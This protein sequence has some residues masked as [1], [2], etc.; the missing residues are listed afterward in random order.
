MQFLQEPPAAVTLVSRCV[1]MS[2]S[3]FADEAETAWR[4]QVTCW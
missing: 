4:L 2:S 3:A 1:L